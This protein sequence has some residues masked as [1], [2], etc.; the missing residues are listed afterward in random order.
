MT[1]P[2]LSKKAIA[3]IFIT[4]FIDTMGFGI[5]MPVTPE[6]LMELTDKTLSEASVYGGWLFFSFAAM[7][8][9]CA[10]ILGNLSD[11][12]GRRPVLLFSLLAF[13]I[14]YTIMGFAQQLSWLFVGRIF[15]GMAGASF[16]SAYACIADISTPE[17][18]AQN[19]G[20]MGAAFGAGFIVGPAIGGL[21]GGFGTR[22]PFFAAATL[23]AC[24]LVFGYLVLQETLR[25][26][27]RRR[28]QWKRANPLGTLLHMRRYPIVLG[29]A[30]VVFLW[31]MGHQ[32]LPSVWAYY[33][34]FK[35]GWTELAV[36]ASLGFA[37]VVMAVGQGGLTRIMIPRLGGERPAVLVGL[38]VA[39]LG[40]FGYAFCSEGWMVYVCM[41][42][43]LLAGLAYPAL[44][45]LMSRQLPATEQGELQGGLASIYSLSAITGPPLMT[46]LF[47]QFSAG[48][49]LMHF[50]GAPFVA[51]GL[52]VLAGA[53]VFARVLR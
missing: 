5:I 47:G 11:R 39:A 30:A 50:P 27:S 10:P 28:F 42:N 53:V 8:F 15:S 26:E 35:F 33:T 6:L 32:V 38:L 51:A 1:Q 40:Y 3:F 34:M 16:S 21:L 52:L 48:R 37:G 46:H 36:G 14:N 43:G 4:V 29:L 49:G 12:F 7:Q 17:K 13:S 20:L 24:N 18:R 45:A 22:A 9:F 19:F 31:Q 2:P 25:P 23:A 41:L 44:T